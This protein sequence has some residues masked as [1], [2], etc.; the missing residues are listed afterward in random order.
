MKTKIIKEQP[1][2]T[3]RKPYDGDDLEIFAADLKTAEVGKR[4]VT[5]NQ[6]CYPNRD[7][8]WDESFT[9]IYKDEHGVCVLY[10]CEEA[11]DGFNYYQP[12]EIE[13]IWVELN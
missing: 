6:N 5:E 9:V 13:L 2:L 7:A 4:W 8:T 3:V 10:R 1:I 12:E 11:G